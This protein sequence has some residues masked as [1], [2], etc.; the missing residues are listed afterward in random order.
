MCLNVLNEILC[1]GP[2]PSNKSI[3][4]QHSFYK[5]YH[6]IKHLEKFGSLNLRTSGVMSLEGHSARR[7]KQFMH[8][9]WL[10]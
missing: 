6:V 4:D 1:Y 7:T 9:P 10:R 5:E 2:F 3:F 8:G